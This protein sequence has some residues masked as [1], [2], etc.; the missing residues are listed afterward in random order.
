MVSRCVISSAGHSGRVSVARSVHQWSRSERR[1]TECFRRCMG[2]LTTQTSAAA[3]HTSTFC[4][5]LLLLLLLLLLHPFNCLFPRSSASWPNARVYHTVVDCNHI[6]PILRFVLHLY[7]VF[8]HY[9]AALSK[10]LAATSHRAVLHHRRS[11]GFRSGTITLHCLRLSH[12]K[13]RP[14]IQY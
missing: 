3:R 2:L 8:L 10:I 4:P 12:R 6:T 1:R 11:T 13:H 14:P 5:L 7:K 9:Y